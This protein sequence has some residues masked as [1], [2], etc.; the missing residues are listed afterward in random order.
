MGFLTYLQHDL[1]N[2]LTE[3]MQGTAGC[4]DTAWT[5]ETGGYLRQILNARVYDVAVSKSISQYCVDLGYIRLSAAP[6][7]C[8]IGHFH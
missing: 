4:Q 1:H 2:M 8:L 3:L 7:F 5:Q 6:P